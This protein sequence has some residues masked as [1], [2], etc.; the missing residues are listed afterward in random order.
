[1]APDPGVAA[2]APAADSTAPADGAAAAAAEPDA[3]RARTENPTGLR[4]VPSSVA[5]DV[6]QKAPGGRDTR[7]A[8]VSVCCPI[9]FGSIALPIPPAEQ[10][11]QS[12]HKWLLY[13]RGAD[14]EDLS[15]FISKVVF[16]LHQSFT[17]NV[18]EVTQHPFE[19]TESGWGEFE[20]R[21]SLHF[22]SPHEKSIDTIQPLRLHPDPTG[23]VGNPKDPVISER[24]D[25]V[26]FTDPHESFFR[27]LAAGQQAPLP[28]HP[29]QQLFYR[30]SD[31]S[32]LQQLAAARDYVH[33]ELEEVKERILRAEAQIKTLESGGSIAEVPQPAAKQELSPTSMNI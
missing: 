14:G 19:I 32:N 1:M 8:G 11:S 24:Y 15:Y 12:T 4:V 18:R 23:P 21:L 3:K 10:T 31:A 13:V 25:E 9:V 20:A 27:L 22:K 16:T 26:V 6:L 29:Y 7:M 5:A 17:P 2:V 33:T 28:G 30:F